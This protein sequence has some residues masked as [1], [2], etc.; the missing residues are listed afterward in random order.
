MGDLY[1]ILSAEKRTDLADAVNEKMPEY[2]PI[3]APQWKQVYWQAMVHSSVMVESAPDQTVTLL[4]HILAD[5][6]Q[7]VEKEGDDSEE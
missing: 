7:L 4:G 2:L 3:G 5:L 6:D 1:I